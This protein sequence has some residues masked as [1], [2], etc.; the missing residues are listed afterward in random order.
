MTSRHVEGSSPE[1][2]HVEALCV[3]QQ[4]ENISRCEGAIRLADD[5]VVAGGLTQA[6]PDRKAI[7]L[8]RLVDL[9]GRGKP[10]LIRGSIRG[11][12]VDDDHFVDNAGAEKVV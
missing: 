1:P 4:L 7:P 2:A 8:R 6:P 3:G 5:Q 11:V 12:V 9:A 10:N